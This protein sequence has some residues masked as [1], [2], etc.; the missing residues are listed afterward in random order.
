MIR[1]DVG[2]IVINLVG[3]FLLSTELAFNFSVRPAIQ[4]DG[5]EARV[6]QGHTAQLFC[7]AEGSPKAR[8]MS[9]FLRFIDANVR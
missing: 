1:L 5:D 9:D 4:T 8:I 6:E 7:R 3:D 2:G